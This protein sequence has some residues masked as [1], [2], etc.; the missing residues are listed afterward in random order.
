[1]TIREMVDSITGQYT[2]T[3][4]IVSVNQDIRWTYREFAE[5]VNQVP[6]ALIGLG[7]EKGDRGTSAR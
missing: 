1:M 3:E 7:V 6:R 2:E 4:A 5:R